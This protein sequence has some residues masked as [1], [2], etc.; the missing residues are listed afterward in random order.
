MN[1]L[2]EENRIASWNP[3]VAPAGALQLGLVWMSQVWCRRVW[4]RVMNTENRRSATRLCQMENKST[5]NI[6]THRL[7]RNLNKVVCFGVCGCINVYVYT[8]ARVHA[9][10]C[11]C[12]SVCVYVYA[13]MHACMCMCVYVRVCV[14]VC[15]CVCAYAC[16]CVYVCVYVCMCAGV[17]VYVCR[18]VGV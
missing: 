11:A 12:M 10:E 15:R 4:V 2:F 18:S 13:C 1:A 5:P 9:C 16:T 8:S 3:P 7:P 14:N 6:R 17:C